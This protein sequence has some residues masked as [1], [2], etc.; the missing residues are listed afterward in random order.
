MTEVHGNTVT[1]NAQ[2]DAFCTTFDAYKLVLSSA[3]APKRSGVVCSARR[4]RY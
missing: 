4:Y 2:T 1:V 3:L